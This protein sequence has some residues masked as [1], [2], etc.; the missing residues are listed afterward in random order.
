MKLGNV[1]FYRGNT[2]YYLSLPCLTILWDLTQSG[3]HLP[4]KIG[5][6][7]CVVVF[8]QMHESWSWRHKLYDRH[9]FLLYS[10]KLLIICNTSNNSVDKNVISFEVFFIMVQHILHSYETKFDL[11]SI[12]LILFVNYKIQSRIPKRPQVHESMSV[13]RVESGTGNRIDGWLIRYS[14]SDD[15]FHV[16][17]QMR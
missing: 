4:R 17:S 12:L 5:I 6:P 15:I 13:E 3:N 1:I 2:V 9:C 10:Y 14:E 7:R 11:C 16:F 8:V